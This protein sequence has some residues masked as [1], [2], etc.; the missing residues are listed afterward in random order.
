MPTRF[1]NTINGDPIYALRAM[2][3][4]NGLDFTQYYAKLTDLPAPQVQADWNVSDSSSKAFILNKPNL[5]LYALS[6]S[7]AAVATSGSYNDLIDKP[8]IPAAQVQSNW[9][10]SDTD[11]VDYIKN[12]PANLVQDAD[13]VHT[14]NNYTDADE[15]KLAGIQAG[16][17]VNVQPNWNQTDSD[18]DDYIKN[19]P[20]IPAAQVQSNW[21]QTDSDAVDFIKNKPS[22]PAAQVQSDWTQSNTDA[23]DYIKNKPTISN[24]PAVTSIDDGKVLKA[25]YSGGVGAYSWEPES[26][27]GGGTIVLIYGTSTWADYLA[28]VA[29]G[30]EILCGEDGAT[31]R[32]LANN[33]YNG[34]DNSVEFQYVRMMN[35]N[36]W[37]SNGYCCQIYKYV[38]K[39]TGSGPNYSQTWTKTIMPVAFT[40]AAGS[41]IKLYNMVTNREVQFAVDIPVYTD[42]N[43]SILWLGANS[44]LSIASSLFASKNVTKTYT[45]SKAGGPVYASQG[46]TSSSSNALGNRF[47]NDCNHS[48]DS[49]TV[50]ISFTGTAA[51]VTA[52]RTNLRRWNDGSN[53]TVNGDLVVKYGLFHYNTLQTSTPYKAAADPKLIVDLENCGTLASADL[54][55]SITLS[56]TSGSFNSVII[57]K[58]TKFFTA[59]YTVVGGV[60]YFFTNT[61]NPYGTTSSLTI[62]ST[63]TGSVAKLVG[64]AP[65]D[66]KEYVRKNG[67]WVERETVLFDDPAPS[68]STTQYMLS[69]S[70]KNFEYA[71][72]VFRTDNTETL[73]QELYTPLFAR[74]VISIGLPSLGFNGNTVYCKSARFSIS[75]DNLTISAVSQSEYTVTSSKTIG[76]Y[77]TQSTAYYFQ[78]VRVVGINRIASN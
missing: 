21:N 49:E 4:K 45:S 31:G 52:N 25:S 24:V 78:L 3:D 2:C 77:T 55:K 38:L 10:Q 69:E 36:Q 30:A 7:L 5:S 73:V 26:G 51:S 27:G 54:N 58:D 56:F 12:K 17:E 60:Q 19:K 29:T 53:Q 33:V 71:K 67:A 68:A 43:N 76:Q 50:T 39:R 32:I 61:L 57:S 13:Y 44:S 22:I 41:G 66:G 40:P 72:F 70:F 9:S 74:D 18:A 42:G 8:V 48:F 47:S 20:T 59:F 16:A 6:S 62:T 35:D 46:S 28:A 37:K 64:E 65:S 34:N 75:S 63:M 1:A 11:A 14:D 23:I 15:A